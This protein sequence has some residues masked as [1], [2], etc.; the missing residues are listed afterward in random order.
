MDAAITDP[1]PSLNH[2]QRSNSKLWAGESPTMFGESA[3]REEPTSQD[4]MPN[5]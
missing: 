4:P 2:G 1:P 5:I 3:F